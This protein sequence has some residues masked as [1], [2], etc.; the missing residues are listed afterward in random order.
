MSCSMKNMIICRLFT[1]FGII[2]EK[3]YALQCRATRIKWAII[4]SI[5]YFNNILKKKKRNQRA[6][7][8]SYQYAAL[9]YN[10]II[11][12]Y[13]LVMS[14]KSNE[15]LLVTVKLLNSHIHFEDCLLSLIVVLR[16]RMY[17]YQIFK[18]SNNVLTFFIFTSGYRPLFV[19]PILLAQQSTIWC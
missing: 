9:I 14:S 13:N 2:L 19:V 8:H 17:F 1:D 18:F 11:Y 3:G 16:C 10:I 12:I 5:M 4:Y 7:L 15:I 6:L